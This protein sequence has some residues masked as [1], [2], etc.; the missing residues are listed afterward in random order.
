MTKGVRRH[1]LTPFFRILNP[2]T[3]L[4]DYHESGGKVQE[5]SVGTAKKRETSGFMEQR[6]SML[7]RYRCPSCIFA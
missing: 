1:G 3:W 5:K 2:D 7:I 4:P 6:E